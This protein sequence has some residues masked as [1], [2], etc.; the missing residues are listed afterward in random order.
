MMAGWD[1][2][3]HAI[4]KHHIKY[5]DSYWISIVNEIINAYDVDTVQYCLT[6]RHTIVNSV[7]LNQ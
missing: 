2:D 7:K 5:S 4:M 3:D 1:R 6:E